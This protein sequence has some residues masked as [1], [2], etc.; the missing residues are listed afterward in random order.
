M[1]VGEGVEGGWG[2]GGRCVTI[3][4]QAGVRRSVTWFFSQQQYGRGL[5]FELR[6]KD[7]ENYTENEGRGQEEADLTSAQG[8][9]V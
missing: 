5:R 9:C 3:R 2:A 8:F 4:R 1:L 6:H 7:E